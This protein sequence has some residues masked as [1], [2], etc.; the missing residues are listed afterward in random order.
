MCSNEE[1]QVLVDMAR[2]QPSF[3]CH[4]PPKGLKPVRNALV[5]CLVP[6]RL[7]HAAWQLITDIASKILL[8]RPS[9]AWARVTPRRPELP[10]CVIRMFRERFHNYKGVLHL[11][12]PAPQCY[13]VRESCTL[14]A[15]AAFRALTSRCRA[16]VYVT[17][18]L[19]RDAA[20]SVGDT[21]L[22][23]FGRLGTRPM[24]PSQ[25]RPGAALCNEHLL[26]S[27]VPDLIACRPVA[28]FHLHDLAC[29]LCKVAHPSRPLSS[30]CSLG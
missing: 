13:V 29:Q 19:P 4:D 10:T 11:H 23:A 28:M 2:K 15:Q 30:E 9:I 6:A 5:R 14:E 25:V 26:S 1:R 12:P 8:E 7:C 27:T 16:V 22:A 24:F 17:G 21:V 18:N 20:Q 3:C